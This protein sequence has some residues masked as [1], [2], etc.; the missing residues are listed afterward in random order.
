MTPLQRV[1]LGVILILIPLWWLTRPELAAPP[2]PQTLS[3]QSD[4]PPADLP[5]WTA[6]FDVSRPECVEMRDEMIAAVA[7]GTGTDVAYIGD[8]DVRLKERGVQQ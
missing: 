6:H 5:P 7:D 4:T 2:S 8:C 1:L 3:D